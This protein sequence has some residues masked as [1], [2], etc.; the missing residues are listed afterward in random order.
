[1]LNFSKHKML[2]SLTF[3]AFLH[4]HAEAQTK[5]GEVRIETSAHIDQ[6][7]AQK[8]DYNKTLETIQFFGKVPA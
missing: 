8:K 4:F 2:I 6:M 7:V 5:E 3:I 1:M